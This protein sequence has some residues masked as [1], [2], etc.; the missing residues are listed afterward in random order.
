MAPENTFPDPVTP[1]KPLLQV[2]DKL[3]IAIGTISAIIF[4]WG[5]KNP[6]TLVAFLAIGFLCGLYVLYHL[7]RLLPWVPKA[8]TGPSRRFAAALLALTI[9]WAAAVLYYGAVNWPR[10]ELLVEVTFKDSPQLTARRRK[11]IEI[12][13]DDYYRY[14]IS[15]GLDLPREVP[16]FG[17]TP[18]GGPEL[19]GGS[20]ASPGTDGP[21]YSSYLLVPEDAVDNPNTIRAVYSS[22]TF[23]RI[24]VWPDAWDQNMSREEKQDDEIAEWVYTCYFSSA[25]SGTPTCDKSDQKTVR[26]GVRRR[27]VVLQPQNV[28]K[29]SI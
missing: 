12:E 2:S 8:G 20:S 7:A 5:E 17:L 3:A 24:L 21:A 19:V 1:A 23:E 4:F 13:L 22:Y 26:A 16:P 11:Q 9:P 27:A 28:A 25:F 15:V 10:R 6:A 29:Y 14:L 18:P